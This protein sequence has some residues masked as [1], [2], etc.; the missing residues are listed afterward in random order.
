MLKERKKTGRIIYEIGFGQIVLEMTKK[1][2]ILEALGQDLA[3]KRCIYQ[4]LSPPWRSES[5]RGEMRLSSHDYHSG[6]LFSPFPIRPTDH[7]PESM[8]T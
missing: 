2:L 5:W 8:G 7:L 3:A 4:N 1:R 6:V